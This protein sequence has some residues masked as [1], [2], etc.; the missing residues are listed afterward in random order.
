MRRQVQNPIK[1]RVAAGKLERLPINIEIAVCQ[2]IEN[3]GNRHRRIEQYIVLNEHP[4]ANAKL[5]YFRNANH[6]GLRVY[7][8][9]R[10]IVWNADVYDCERVAVHVGFYGRKLI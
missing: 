9:W 7:E 6:A 10:G 2:R 8:D 3:A 1:R 4:Y 5:C